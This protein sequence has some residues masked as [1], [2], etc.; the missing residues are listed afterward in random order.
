[1]LAVAAALAGCTEGRRS[2]GSALGLEI[3][4]PN[5]FNVAPRAPLRLP[6]DLG[7]LPPPQPGAPS[8]LDPQPRAAA[9]AALAQAGRPDAPEAA[10]SPGELSLLDAAGADLADPRIRASLRAERPERDDRFGLSSFLGYR[11]PDGSERE[12]LSPREEAERL[13]EAGETAP[14]APPLPAEPPS[15]EW[16][17]PLGDD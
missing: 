13:R 8:P 16:V 3:A 9:Q 12:I 6:S 11:V 7:A 2:L 1:M 17:I 15:D 4:S 14:N 10:P 5:P